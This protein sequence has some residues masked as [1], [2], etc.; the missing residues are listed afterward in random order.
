MQSDCVEIR[1]D[2]CLAADAM[3]LLEGTL[4]ASFAQDFVAAARSAGASVTYRPQQGGHWYSYGA[5]QLGDAIN[6]WGLFAPVASRPRGW[7]YSTVSQTGDMWGM[8][9]EFASPP[10]TVQ[11]F[12]RDGNVLRGQGSGTVLI[13]SRGACSFEA[14]LPFERTLP[15]GDC[16]GKQR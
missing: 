1:Y 15:H 14:V 8:R 16:P 10:E 9:F 4:F 12:A 5:R 6:N 2:A 11:T 3:G 7:T 13:Q